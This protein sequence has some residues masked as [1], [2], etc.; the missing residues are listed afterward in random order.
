MFSLDDIYTVCGTVIGVNG[1]MVYKGG[2]LVDDENANAPDGFYLAGGVNGPRG[3][4][5]TDANTVYTIDFYLRT[6]DKWTWTAAIDND[7]VIL[8]KFAL[9]QNYPNPFNPTTVIPFILEKSS[10]VRLTIYDM[11]GREIETLLDNKMNPGNYK[12][13]FDAT[14][15][16]SGTYVYRLDVDGETVSKKMLYVK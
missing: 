10:I 7:V 11:L 3:G 14:G 6:L 2:I 15:L 8:D 12:I 13:N 1:V 5:F 16:A 4:F 9:K